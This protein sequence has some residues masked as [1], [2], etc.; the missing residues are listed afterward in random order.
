MCQFVRIGAHR[1]HNK[2]NR[3]FFRGFRSAHYSRANRLTITMAVFMTLHFIRHKGN[4]IL[5]RIG[6]GRL[7][8]RQICKFDYLGFDGIAFSADTVA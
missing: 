3:A 5:Q 4:F 2:G 1:A 6:R 8:R 7:E